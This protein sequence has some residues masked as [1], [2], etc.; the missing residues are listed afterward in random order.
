[1][2]CHYDERILPEL[3]KTDALLARAKACL[4]GEGEDREER[5]LNFLIRFTCNSLA[6]ES[7]TATE[8][9]AA[10]ILRGYDVPSLPLEIRV[11]LT[12]CRDA[13]YYMRG[14]VHAGEPLTQEMI[15]MVHFLCTPMGDD[16]RGRYR[17]VQIHVPVRTQVPPEP[18]EVPGA[19]DRL[20]EEYARCE[21]HPLL[22]AAWFHLAHESIH[23]LHLG[24]LVIAHKIKLFL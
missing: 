1:M 16:E 24:H 20:M 3:W 2:L 6:I 22:L 15:R 23:P 7:L 13:F 11:Q 12:G 5:L 9:K 14:R 19:M 18:E 10:R 21:L 17:S 4:P 8:E